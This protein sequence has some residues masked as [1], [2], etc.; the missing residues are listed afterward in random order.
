[1]PTINLRPEKVQINSIQGADITLPIRVVQDDGTTPVNISALTFS[2]DVVTGSGAIIEALTEGSGITIVSA[3]GGTLQINIEGDNLIFSG[4]CDSKLYGTLWVVASG[5]TTAYAQFCF[6][7]S[8]VIANCSNCTPCTDTAFDGEI[9]IQVP[10]TEITIV[11]N[12]ALITTEQII[13]AL[14]GLT[15]YDSDEAAILDGLGENDIYW[16]SEGSTLGLAGF[17]KRV[18]IP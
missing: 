7:L 11:L 10:N 2:M 17:L 13:E 16:Q 3:V 5:I 1:M 14:S 12:T 4:N 18:I 8:P 15:E 9:V 6:N